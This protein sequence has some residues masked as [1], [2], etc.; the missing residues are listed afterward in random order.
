MPTSMPRAA[1]A[2]SGFTVAATAQRTTVN[3]AM[4]SLLDVKWLPPEAAPH[5][6]EP[7]FELD[8]RLPAQHLHSAGDVGPANLWVVDWQRLE[9]DLAR[10]RGDS[11][12]CLRKLP[13]GKLFGVAKVH[14]Q[15]LAALGEQVKAA[16]QV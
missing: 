8:F 15:V 13:N 16:D 9:D 10:G 5:P 4:L 3:R 1:A 7:F 12:D 11:D 14:G 2:R 6:P